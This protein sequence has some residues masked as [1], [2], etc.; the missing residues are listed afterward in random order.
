VTTLAEY[1]SSRELFI[2]LTLRELRS[3]YKR[4]A[5]GWG[6]SMVNPLASTIVYTIVFSKFFH[7]HPIRGYP[8]GLTQYALWL[9]PAMLAWN[10]FQTGIN[11]S[12][13]T[14][15][16]NGN[17]IKK[18]Y[19]PRELMPASAVAAAL[20]SHFIEMGVVLVVMLGFGNY[21]AAVYVPF[22]IV[23][24]L[25]VAIFSLGLGLALSALNVY[26][27]DIQHFL[28]ILFLLWMYAT[29][30]IYPNYLVNLESRSTT[31]IYKHNGI[32]SPSPHP[33]WKEYVIGQY[34]YF[35]GTHIKFLS[36]MKINPITEMELLLRQTMWN[37]TF[38]NWGNL[39]YLAAWAF[40]ALWVGLV[41][42]RR[43]EGRLAE[44]L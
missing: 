21:Y 44:E 19:F 16:G 22:T 2:N 39:A 24:I 9:L 35:P 5:L 12:V 43:F 34:R 4:S 32:V 1:R 28:N 10:F 26:Y 15:I 3:K 41:V 14:L 40:A 17:L 20:V 23:I 7:A 25:L 13:G 6:W 11:S 42:F 37:G 27:R 8:S 38:P 33:G 30:I 36:V 29:P 31:Q 18:T